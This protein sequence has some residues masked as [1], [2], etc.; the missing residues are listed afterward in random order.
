MYCS[1]S[2]YYCD[3]NERN[4]KVMNDLQL[5]GARHEEYLSDE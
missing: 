2:L 1:V 5:I 3:V 4:T